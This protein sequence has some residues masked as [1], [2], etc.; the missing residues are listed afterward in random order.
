MKATT[1]SLRLA[2]EI[3]G[4]PLGQIFQLRAMD[5]KHYDR[6]FP[7]MTGDTFDL[8]QILAWRTA[9]S[10]SINPP[11]TDTPLSLTSPV[12]KPPESLK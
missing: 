9:K 12:I 5:C 3:L 10:A 6:T 1:I 4:V 7:K 2:A 11:V 8:E